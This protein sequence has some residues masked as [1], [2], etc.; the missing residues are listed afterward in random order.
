MHEASVIELENSRVGDEFIDRLSPEC[1][2][3]YLCQRIQAL[4]KE[5]WGSGL[6]GG[7]EGQS[8]A[9]VPKS[10]FRLTSCWYPL[11]STA[12]RL[13]LQVSVFLRF[14]VAHFN[15]SVF[16]TLLFKTAI[17]G[18]E[19]QCQRK[20]MKK[21]RLTRPSSITTWQRRSTDKPRVW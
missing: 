5:I 12:C 20:K 9:Q 21:R 7:I 3:W 13:C 10:F 2:V 19:D 14:S 16:L 17:R 6:E 4:Q 15:I 11:Q 1:S 18:W 8:R